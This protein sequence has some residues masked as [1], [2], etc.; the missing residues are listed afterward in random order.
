MNVI[1]VA[2]KRGVY[3]H[4]VGFSKAYNSQPKHCIRRKPQEYSCAFSN[5]Y[6]ARYPKLQPTKA[7]LI[8][9][10]LLATKTV[11]FIKFPICDIFISIVIIWI[12]LILLH[13]F[14][15][16]VGNRSDLA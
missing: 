14:A 5:P 13:N 1:E 2:N 10:C 16:D 15:S 4:N 8:T 11:C 9:I 7:L 12:A 3:I 6:L